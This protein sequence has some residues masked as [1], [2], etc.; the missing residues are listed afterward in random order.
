MK[1]IGDLGGI[2]EDMDE[3]ITIFKNDFLANRTLEFDG[4]K[5]L[6]NSPKMYESLLENPSETIKALTTSI[7]NRYDNDINIR[8]T[9][10]LNNKEIHKIRATDI[11][12]FVSVKGIIKRVTKVL[13]RI[14]V[15]KYECS[16]CGSLISISQEKKKK[17]RPSRCACGR[18]EGFKT[19]SEEIVDIQEINLEE[20]QDNLDG[21]QPQQI[22]VYLENE[23]TEVN[24]SNKLRAGRKIEII[25]EIKKLPAFMTLKDEETNLSEFMISA[26]N[27]VPLESEEDETITE[28]DEKQIK[29]IASANPLEQLARSLAPEIFGNEI[30]KKALVLQMARAVPKARSDGT[31]SKEDINVLLSGDV[32]IAKSRMLSSVIARTPR[33]KTVVGTKTSR[34]GLGA[35]AVKDE[36]TNT[37]ALEIGALVLCNGTTLGIDEIDKMYKEHLSE[38]LEPMSAGLVTINKAGIS[39]VLPAR[40]SILAAANP[41]HGNYNLTQPLAKQIDLP[42]PILNR[43]DL[44]FILLDKPNR[45]FDYDVVSHIFKSMNDLP[46]LDISIE[47]FKKYITYCRQL[48]PKL[49]PEIERELKDFYVSIRQGS[50][51]GESNE[52]GIPINI[53]NLE[54]LIRL[55]EAHAK[56]RLSE[57]VEITDLEVAKEIFMFCLKQIGIDENGLIDQSRITHKVPFSKKGKVESMLST[58]QQMAQDTD[59]FIPL[60]TIEIE[61]DAL[62]IKKWEVYDFLEELKKQGLLIESK[63][64]YYTVL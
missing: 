15:I 23:L 64:G 6:E 46:E 58:L 33:A 18:T 16:G 47:M 57:W 60:K 30:V 53:R 5:L 51:V 31:F 27:V 14:L 41:I 26:N 8:F 29:E 21:K 45:Q 12:K 54:G 10:I 34:V 9:N 44:I 56:L 40:T 28:E 63:K 32:G 36:L 62:G 38:L 59:N 1:L 37:W 49:K 43:F 25:G 20:I 35:M 61:S 2:N 55:A 19:V 3:F 24:Y 4:N 42:S 50:Q 17:N 48:R 39:A 22:R 7:K 11:G 13:P 52:K